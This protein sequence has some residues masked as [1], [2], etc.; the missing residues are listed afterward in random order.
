MLAPVKNVAMNLGFQY[1]FELMFL[2]SLL[3][4][5]DAELLDSI[6][7]LF[8]IF[9][10]LHTVLHSVCINLHSH[11]A[12]SLSHICFLLLHGLYSPSG[13]SVHGIL[14]ARMLEW[15]ASPFSRGSSKSKDWAWVS[16]I[17]GKFFT[18]WVTREAYIPTN[19]AQRFPFL[20]ILQ[21]SYLLSFSS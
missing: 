20:H 16:C 1:L 9:E 12:Q 19:I 10:Q 17:T 2:C 5:S 18:F 7:D 6:G 14:Q 3:K 11:W 13:S 4:Y 15:V 8:L 21:H